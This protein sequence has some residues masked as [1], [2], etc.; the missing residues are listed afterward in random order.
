MTYELSLRTNAK[1]LSRSS[2]EYLTA[3][4]TLVPIL[5]FDYE[6]EHILGKRVQHVIFTELLMTQVSGPSMLA[7]APRPATE[8]TM[9]ERTNA[10]V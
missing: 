10:V 6:P 9:A 5:T 8:Y 4:R 7:R 2:T 3:E 1:H